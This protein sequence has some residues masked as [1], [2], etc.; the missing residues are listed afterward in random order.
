MNEAKKREQLLVKARM[1]Q[2]IK[3]KQERMYY[4]KKI[5]EEKQRDLESLRK[6]KEKRMVYVH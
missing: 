1:D 3:N 2:Q 5:A 4:E 6:E